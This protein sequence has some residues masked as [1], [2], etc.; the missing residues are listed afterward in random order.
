[1]VLNM[2][3]I[4]LTAERL[5]EQDNT[6]N[7]EMSDNEIWFVKHFIKKYNPKKIVEIG[8]S[9]GGNTV[10]LLNWKDENAQLFSIDIAKEWYRDNTKLSGFMAEELEIKDNW[11]LYRGYDYLDVFEEIGN[12]IDLIII[13]TV[14]SMPGEFF[15]FLAALPQLKDGC[16]VILHDIHLNMVKFNYNQFSSYDFDAY[17]TGLLFGGVSSTKKWTLKPDV[18]T[19]I[20]AFIVDIYTRNN[21]KD[22][23]HILCTSWNYFP[24]ELNLSKYSEFIDKKY[25]IDCFNLFKSCLTLQSKSFYYAEKQIAKTARIDILN[26]NID[27]NSIEILNN[28]KSVDVIFPDW[29]KYADGKGAVIQTNEKSFDLKFQCINKGLLNI[30]LRGPDVHDKS[31]KRIPSYVEFNKV[32]MNN[33]DIINGDVLVWHDEPYTFKKDVDDGE[34]IEIH[35]EWSFYKP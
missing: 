30:I 26:S 3:E 8:I 10:N 13:D 25:P 12:D 28:P 7:V 35:V 24:Q 22:V 4:E 19:N 15:T 32:S 11:K 9:A 14:H 2:V 1:M 27:S 34:H 31:G 16:I 23:F 29:F 6:L 5:D 33:E 18:I 17:C 20:G 21:I